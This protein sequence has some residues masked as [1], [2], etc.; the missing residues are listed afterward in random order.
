MN[1]LWINIRVGTWH[2]TSGPDDWLDIS[3]NLYHKGWPQGPFSIYKLWNI[4]P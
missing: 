4:V 3:R 2:F 1:N